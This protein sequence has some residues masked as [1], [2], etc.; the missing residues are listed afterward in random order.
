MNSRRGEDAQITGRVRDR[1]YEGGGWLHSVRLD[2]EDGHELL[3]RSAEPREP[4]STV[5]LA[6]A[7]PAFVPGGGDARPREETA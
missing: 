3:V 5:G 4:G 2:G 7:R 6:A 1:Y